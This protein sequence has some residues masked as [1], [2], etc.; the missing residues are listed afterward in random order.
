MSKNA[1]TKAK[2]A[3]AGSSRWEVVTKKDSA[4]NV[5]RTRRSDAE[6]KELS[7]DR[8]LSDIQ[9]HSEGEIAIEDPKE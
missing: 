9:I 7:V 2:T 5:V 1:N 3:A 8:R 4:F 6:R